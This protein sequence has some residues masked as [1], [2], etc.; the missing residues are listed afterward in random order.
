MS[1]GA[2]SLQLLAGYGDRREC[3]VRREERY[4]EKGKVQNENWRRFEGYA[5][6]TRL[7]LHRCRGAPGKLRFGEEACA[8]IGIG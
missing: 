8:K 4:K 3:G 7:R 6:L 1:R 2:V 5:C